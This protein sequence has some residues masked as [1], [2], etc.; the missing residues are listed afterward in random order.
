MNKFIVNSKQNNYHFNFFPI[1]EIFKKQLIIQGLSFDFGKIDYTPKTIKF[2]KLILEL[3]SPRAIPILNGIVFLMLDFQGGLYN[4]TYIKEKEDT[5]R[6]YVVDVL[7]AT[8]NESQ[9]VFKIDKTFEMV[10]KF[11]NYNITQ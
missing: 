6:F 1:H 8:D 3:E 7:L 2:N 11:K 4:T 9:F 5:L 10:F